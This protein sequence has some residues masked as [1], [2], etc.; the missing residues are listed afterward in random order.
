MLL[1]SKEGLCFDVSPYRGYNSIYCGI[2]RYCKQGDIL[3]HRPVFLCLHELDVPTSSRL[4][5]RIKVKSQMAEDSVSILNSPN[6]NHHIVSYI[7][8]TYMKS[9]VSGNLHAVSNQPLVVFW[10]FCKS[11]FN[12]IRKCKSDAKHLSR[13]VSQCSCSSWNSNCGLSQQDTQQWCHTN[14]V[15][16]L[17]L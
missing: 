1:C 7:T 5:W 13:N 4:T 2:L 16:K 9:K 14:T 12:H 11:H 17:W 6:G 10:S 8:Q 15:C 3:F